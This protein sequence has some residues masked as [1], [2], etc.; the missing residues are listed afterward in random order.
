M[1]VR[2]SEKYARQQPIELS[3]TR[4]PV[5]PN[6]KRRK[7]KL[8]QPSLLRSDYTST[9]RYYP[10]RRWMEINRAIYKLGANLRRWPLKSLSPNI[11]HLNIFALREVNI[12]LGGLSEKSDDESKRVLSV[13]HWTTGAWTIRSIDVEPFSIEFRFHKSCLVFKTSVSI[14]ICRKS[15]ILNHYLTHLSDDDFS[16]YIINNNVTDTVR[17][18]DLTPF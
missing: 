12:L 4:F 18:W 7:A 2:L 6:K 10:W 16:S 5:T 8:R 13:R 11:D 14:R 15:L 1:R 17:T 3:I 9:S